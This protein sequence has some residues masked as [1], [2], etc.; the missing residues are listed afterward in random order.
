M[1]KPLIVLL[2]EYK[3]KENLSYRQL[4]KFLGLSYSHVA[5]VMQEKKEISWNFCEAVARAFEMP[6]I[7]AFVLGGLMTREE[8]QAWANS[9]NKKESRR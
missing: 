6:K 7:T 9:A 1:G 2:E 8:A 5:N 3:K 4:G